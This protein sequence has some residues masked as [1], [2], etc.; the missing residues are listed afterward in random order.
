MYRLVGVV[1]DVL[2]F[3]DVSLK[4]NFKKLDRLI[5]CTDDDELIFYIA[6]CMKVD[7]FELR[8]SFHRNH[9]ERLAKVTFLFMEGYIVMTMHFEVIIGKN[10]YYAVGTK[11][12]T[13]KE[14]EK[15]SI[16]MQ[17]YKIPYELKHETWKGWEVPVEYKIPQPGHGNSDTY[18]CKGTL[19]VFID[20]RD[21]SNVDSSDKYYPY[22]SVHN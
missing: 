13:W 9:Y 8:N 11:G 22:P 14:N 19:F 10:F 1:D 2:K 20:I 6:P 15:L 18:R 5:Y 17:D 7:L 3:E 16:H 4:L 12:F 21:R